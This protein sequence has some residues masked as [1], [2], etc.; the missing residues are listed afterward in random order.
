MSEKSQLGI[1]ARIF[2]AR[3]F[4]GEQTHTYRLASSIRLTWGL[5][6]AVLL[7][8]SVS[9]GF[10]VGRV[11]EEEFRV[12]RALVQDA[13]G[14]AQQAAQSVRRSVN[15]GV[16]DLVQTEKLLHG[17]DG[18]QVEK[19]L[20]SADTSKDLVHLLR[21]VA[22]IHGRYSSIFILSPDNEVIASV[23]SKARPELMRP[24]PPYNASGASE[25]I[26]PDGGAPI[27][28]E[29]APMLLDDG[30]Y[31]T[32]AATYDPA[33]LVF[34]L[35]AAI[36]GDAWVVDPSGKI[37]GSLQPSGYTELPREQLQEA[38]AQASQGES[39]ALVTSGSIDRQE[40]IGYAP[41]AGEGPGGQLGWSVVTAKSVASLALPQIQVRAQ[42]LL[43]GL[44]LAFVSVLVF[45]WLYLVVVSP[46]MRLQSEA[47]RLAFGDLAKPV[48]IVRFDE[49]GLIARALERMRI[50]L[51]RKQARP[52]QKKA[53]PK[54]AEPPSPP[55]EPEA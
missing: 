16:A 14:V 52:I 19:L 27:I 13:A 17:V 55:S 3:R 1:V 50:L 2:R 43:A 7:I 21:S 32:V 6:L 10:L 39:G 53:P 29:Y 11:D 37:V 12:P 9:I 30:R 45:G 8:I 15:E 38:A 49:I 33:F 41:V 42:G 28:F 5:G 34:P 22:E 44:V 23:G 31:A 36:P 26:A 18:R 51:I 47:E 35:E 24:A 46:I 25:V 54:E 4:S 48:E 40:L 20:E